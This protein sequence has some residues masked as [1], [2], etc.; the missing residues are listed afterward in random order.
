M[1]RGFDGLDYSLVGAAAAQG[2][3]HLRD[4]LST[5]WPWVPA[6]ERVRRQQHAR[7]AKAALKRAVIN[8]GLLQG[9]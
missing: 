1:G 6:Q 7:G 5:R 3:L 2:A 8:E 9:V 4:D